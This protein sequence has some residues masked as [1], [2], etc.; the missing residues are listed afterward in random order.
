MDYDMD[1]ERLDDFFMKF[2]SGI[3]RFS[4]IVVK[5]AGPDT[6]VGKVGKSLTL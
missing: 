1:K 3:S 6:G 4:K 2:I 5:Y